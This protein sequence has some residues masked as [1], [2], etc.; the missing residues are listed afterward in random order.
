MARFRL[1]RVLR[2]RAQQ[3][4]LAE[5]AVGETVAAIAAVDTETEQLRQRQQDDW[6]TTQRTLAAG[7]TVAE[8]GVWTDWLAALSSRE[9]WTLRR[10][11]DLSREL[12]TRRAALM[13]TRTEERKLERLRERWA[14]RVAND[15]RHAEERMLDE[16]ALRGH[17][18]RR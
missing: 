4:Q 12:V 6:T 7:I 16:L 2:L 18:T 14:E 1:T 15:V 8:L 17:E 3:R 5:R 10:R 9:A 11:D 13:A